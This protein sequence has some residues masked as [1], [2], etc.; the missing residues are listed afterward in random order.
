VIKNRYFPRNVA[1]KLHVVNPRRPQ[2]TAQG[3]TPHNDSPSVDTDNSINRSAK[4]WLHIGSTNIF[5]WW[6]SQIT[7]PFHR[8]FPAIKHSCK[9]WLPVI[10]NPYS[11]S[12][13]RDS[14]L[15]ISLPI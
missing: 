9:W 5:G 2:S 11:T 8:H 15:F 10:T 13:F 12:K 7:A 6:S 4:R 3:L 1:T 14:Q